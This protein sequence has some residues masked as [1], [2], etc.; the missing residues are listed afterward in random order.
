MRIGKRRGIATLV[1]LIL[2]IPVLFILAVLVTSVCVS[3]YHATVVQHALG[4]AIRQISIPLSAEYG[5]NQARQVIEDVF[6]AYGVA[7]PSPDD[8][9]IRYIAGSAD[10]ARDGRILI[11]IRYFIPVGSGL[12]TFLSQRTPVEYHY[13]LPIERYNARYIN[14]WTTCN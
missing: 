4:A 7:P 14:A 1:G 5:C 8:I 3:L 11:R 12:A 2:T 9:T 10:G 6:N 13:I